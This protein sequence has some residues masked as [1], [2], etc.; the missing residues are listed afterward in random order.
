MPQHFRLHPAG[1]GSIKRLAV[2][3]E[4][5][6]CVATVLMVSAVAPSFATCVAVN[7]LMSVAVTEMTPNDV[8]NDFES[9]IRSSGH[10]APLWSK[11]NVLF[12]SF[13]WC[14]VVL[15]GVLC[16]QLVHSICFFFIFFYFFYV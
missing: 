15:T 7:F 10:L 3:S 16:E 9:A 8:G 5:V 6:I 2:S 13:L 1:A 11:E 12:T 14:Q 4:W